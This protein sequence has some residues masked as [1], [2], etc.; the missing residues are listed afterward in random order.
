LTD[1]LQASLDA[2]RSRQRSATSRPNL[3]DEIARDIRERILGGHLRPGQRLNQDALAVAYAVSKQP[4][5]EALLLLESEGLVDSH[6]RRGSFVAAISEEDVADHFLVFGLLSGMAAERA[7]T[8]LEPAVL[9]ELGR[10]IGEMESE[11]DPI[12]LE[13]LNF[14]FHRHINRAGAT[15]KLLSVITSLANSIPS[16][17]YEETAEWN[18]RALT[19]HKQIY[20]ALAAR[21]GASAKAAMEVHLR[22]SAVYAVRT[23]REAGFWQQSGDDFR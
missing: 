14:T 1:A 6:L 11:T 9:S 5:R 2:D 22:N 13:T 23:L 12:R 21:D 10:V 17:F 20:D 15:R 7:A 18:T 19:D 8:T 4:V 3:K 16:H